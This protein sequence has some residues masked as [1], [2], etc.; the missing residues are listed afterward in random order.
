MKADQ[1]S[2]AVMN[3]SELRNNINK[4]Y[5]AL[6][7]EV[8]GEFKSRFAQMAVMERQARAVK[9]I[10]ALDDAISAVQDVAMDMRRVEKA[11]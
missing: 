3:T 9:A 2:E 7:S 4:I 5:W 6:H 10:R 1:L 11:E 8:G